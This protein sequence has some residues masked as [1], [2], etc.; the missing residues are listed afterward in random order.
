LKDPT[1]GEILA[2]NN[3]PSSATYIQLHSKQQ[4]NNLNNL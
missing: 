4:K 1:I 2:V 3:L